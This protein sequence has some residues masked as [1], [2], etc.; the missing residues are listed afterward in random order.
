[1]SANYQESEV[2]VYKML[3]TRLG[4]KNLKIGHINVNSLLTKLAD[5]H[6]LLSD[7]E[8]DLLGIT[9]AHLTDEISSYLIKVTGYNLARHDRTGSKGGGVVIYYRKGLNVYEDLKGN[10]NQELGAVWLNIPTQP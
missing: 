4:N 1:M 9:E 6:L 8:F 10:T 2:D 7:V 3:R 5:I